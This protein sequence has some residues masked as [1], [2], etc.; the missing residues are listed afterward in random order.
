MPGDHSDLEMLMPRRAPMLGLIALLL[1]ACSKAGSFE[2]KWES[3]FGGVTLELKADR[4]ALLSV[5]G[6]ASEGT[7]EPDG[8]NRIIVH[9]P[10]QDMTLT[11]NEQGDL[12][13]GMAGRFVKQ[14]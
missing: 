13:D 1:A 7:W 11:L 4:T 3:T 6:I 8:K 14:K 2:G 12:T 10:Q 5:V 9:G